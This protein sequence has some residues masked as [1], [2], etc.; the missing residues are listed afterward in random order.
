MLINPSFHVTA[1]GETLAQE[2]AS[3]NIRVLTLIPGGF[4]TDGTTGTPILPP[5]TIPDYAP[6]YT[7]FQKLLET[8][9]GSQ[10]GE[11]EKYG[12]LVV[13]VVRGEG[14]MKNE[15]TGEVRRWPE[16]LFVGT[17]CIDA[18]RLQREGFESSIT[19]LAI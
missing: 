7:S 15:G 4:F 9:S 5:L 6:L 8:F 3:F 11:V 17:D 13:D 14:L 19:S 12:R 2:V 1:Y 10:I 16:R 18:V